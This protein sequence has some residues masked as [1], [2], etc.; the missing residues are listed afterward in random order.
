MENQGQFINGQ[1]FP[2]ESNSSDDNNTSE[3]L[4]PSGSND[5]ESEL[6]SESEEIM[7]P[8]YTN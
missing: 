3:E 4:A 7:F 5:L 6:E 2:E 1:N 8:A